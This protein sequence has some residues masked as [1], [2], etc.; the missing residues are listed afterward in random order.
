M[1]SPPMRRTPSSASPRQSRDI[2]LA[3]GDPERRQLL[4]L[5]FAGARRLTLG[6]KEVRDDVFDVHVRTAVTESGRQAHQTTPS[7]FARGAAPRGEFTTRSLDCLLLAS[8]PLSQPRRSP[9]PS[10]SAVGVQSSA[11]TAHHVVIAGGRGGE[12][13]ELQN[14]SLTQAVRQG[15]GKTHG[16]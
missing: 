8:N 6:V 3:L 1:S 16:R 13:Q 4:H 10:V 12:D 2:D 5:G 11:G 15:S 7:H 14:P 9:Y